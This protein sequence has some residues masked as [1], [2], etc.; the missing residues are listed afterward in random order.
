MSLNKITQISLIIEKNP[1]LVNLFT[2]H[3]H[4]SLQRQNQTEN[5]LDESSEVTEFLKDPGTCI[6][7]ILVERMIWLHIEIVSSLNSTESLK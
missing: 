4:A 7:M 6:V 1:I 3:M 2:F 5:C